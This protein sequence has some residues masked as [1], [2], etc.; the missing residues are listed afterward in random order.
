MRILAAFLLAAVLADP[1][2]AQEK[3]IA[4]TGAHLIPITGP[5]IDNGVL[6]TQAGKIVAVGAADAVQIPAEADRVDC[7]GKTIMPGLVDT[8]SHLG[9]PFAADGS[10]PIQPD[11]RAM[12]AVNVRD[13]GFQKA[14]AGG[15]TTANSIFTS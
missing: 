1:S 8:H 10:S 15:I 12:D 9:G 5:E 7:A 6:V 2:L 14:Q 13:V 4:Y 11:V 3:P